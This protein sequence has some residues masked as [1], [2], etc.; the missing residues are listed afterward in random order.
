MKQQ[1]AL[2]LEFVSRERVADEFA[3]SRRYFDG[4]LNRDAF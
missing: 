2:D 1:F 4:L 3:N